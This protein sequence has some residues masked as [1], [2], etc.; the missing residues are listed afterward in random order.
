MVDRMDWIYVF[1]HADGWCIQYGSVKVVR[2]G[3]QDLRLILPQVREEA[4][5]GGVPLKIRYA[6]GK[7]STYQWHEL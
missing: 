1:L 7:V 5:A 6:T 2:T 4:K 3:E